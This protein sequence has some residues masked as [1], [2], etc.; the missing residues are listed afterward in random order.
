MSFT[1]TPYAA[2]G[3]CLVY[4][5]EN[6]V[7]QLELQAPDDAGDYSDEVLDE[8]VFVQ[9]LIDR[10]GAVLLEAVGVNMADST[11]NY[12]QFTLASA[13]L[14]ALVPPGKVGLDVRYV[15]FELL[16]T[17]A[18]DYLMQPATFSI[19]VLDDPGM[20]VGDPPPADTVAGAARFVIFQTPQSPRLIISQ[21]GAR[22]VPGTGVAS[23]VGYDDAAA[24][25]GVTTVQEAIDAL[26]A[27]HKPGGN[28]DFSQPGNPEIEIIR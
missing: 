9:R 17:G 18:K 13:E 4:A 27:A 25:L 11:G 3:S 22:G 12:S 10:S 5:G 7:L 20:A 26:A 15:L 6:A 23:T 19:R 1:R 8:R 21:R 16:T 2:D 24:G 28:T 14:I